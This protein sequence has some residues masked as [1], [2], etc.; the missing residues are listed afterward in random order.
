MVD[1]VLNDLGGPAGKGFDPGLK[2]RRLP[3][4][5]NGLITLSG[6]RAAQ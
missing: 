1:L 4:R 3:L 6:T 5:L 2:L